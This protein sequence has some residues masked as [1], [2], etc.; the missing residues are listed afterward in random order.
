MRQQAEQVHNRYIGFIAST[1]DY[2]AVL[3]YKNSRGDAWNSTYE[4]IL[5]HIANHGTYHRGQIASRLKEIGVQP[6]TTDY[7]AYSRL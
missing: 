3:E 5:T 1:D 7:I 2:S 4:D 6:P